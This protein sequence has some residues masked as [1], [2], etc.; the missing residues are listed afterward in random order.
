MPLKLN[1]GLCK[2]L[3]LPDYGSLGATC[4]LELELDQS[5]LQ[6]DLDRFHQRIRDAYTACRQA[7]QDSPQGSL[8]KVSVTRL[9]HNFPFPDLLDARWTTTPAQ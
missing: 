2:K 7:V 1:V 6:H 9:A 5:L 4:H 3:G 8:R